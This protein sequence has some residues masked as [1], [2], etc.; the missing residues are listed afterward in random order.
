MKKGF[1]I[2][3]LMIIIVT[4]ILIIIVYLVITNGLKNV[5]G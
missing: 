5:L 1:A 2:T 4:I 3:E